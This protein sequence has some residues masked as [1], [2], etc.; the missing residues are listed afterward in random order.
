MRQAKVNRDRHAVS[1]EF[2]FK[3]IAEVQGSAAV[4]DMNL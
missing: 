2:S 1:I 3:K 4:F